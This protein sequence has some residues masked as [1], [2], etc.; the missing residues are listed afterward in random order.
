MVNSTIGFLLSLALFSVWNASR[1]GSARH[2]ERTH[3]GV[4]MDAVLRGMV[5]SSSLRHGESYEFSESD[6]LTSRD[7]QFLGVLLDCTRDGRIDQSGLT[8][9]LSRQRI[10]CARS[11]ILQRANRLVEMGF[12]DKT[13]FKDPKGR[14]CNHRPSVEF[15][16]RSPEKAKV[17]PISAAMTRLN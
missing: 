8:A 1:W 4:R 3:T 7:K 10:P 16:L 13:I 14:Q 2:L 15:V 6:Y 9:E 12:L 11:T 5:F 17:V